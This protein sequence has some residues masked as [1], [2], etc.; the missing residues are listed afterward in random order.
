MAL[1]FFRRLFGGSE[2]AGVHADPFQREAPPP[3]AVL[4]PEPAPPRPLVARDEIID[5][6]TRICGY[7]YRVSDQGAAPAQVVQALD[8]AG[9]GRMAARR[10]ALLPMDG[11]RWRGASCRALTGPGT[12][13][14][15]ASLAAAEPALLAEIKAA[16][17]RSAIHVTEVNLA[18]R[19]RLGDFALAWVDCTAFPLEAFEKLLRELRRVAPALPI[20]VDGVASWPERRLCDALGVSYCLGGFVASFDEAQAQEKL[21]ESRMVLLEM[22]N[23]LRQDGELEDLAELARRDPAVSVQLVSMANS[24][25]MGLDRQ[26]TGVEQ[27]MLIL[28]RAQLYRWLALAMF[29]VG[30]SRGKDESLL[31]LALARGRFLE[32]AFAP[33]LP[34]SQC[35]E[36]FLVGLLSVFDALLGQPMARILASMHLPDAVQ[37]LLLHNEGAYV[38]PFLLVMAVERGRLEQM[39]RLAAQLELP[40]EQV[41]ACSQAARDWADAAMGFAAGA[42]AGPGL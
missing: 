40:L 15:F 33:L 27:A 31:E 2:P 20:A 30:G 37:A 21:S 29:R 26:I 13:Y 3:A 4:V 19:A 24:P 34:P 5:A 28:G 39:E 35:D 8:E 6:Q 22:L 41:Q 12:H 18:L 36:L 16:G 10:L 11:E 25:A 32:L 17:G 1:G 9:M 42:P 23:L 38:R 14:L 7:H